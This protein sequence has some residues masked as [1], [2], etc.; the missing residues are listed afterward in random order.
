MRNARLASLA[1][2]LALPL[3]ASPRAIA[4]DKTKEA[5]VRQL[6]QMTDAEKL[7]GQVIDAMLGQVEQSGKLPPG[8]SDKF[9]EE[10]QKDK[11]VDRLVPI[12]MKRLDEKDIDGVIA[13]YKSPAGQSFLK[14]QPMIIQDE[15]AA[16]NAWGQSLYEKTM[17]DLG[18]SPAPQQ[19]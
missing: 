11:L 13:F 6:I 14:A 9:R 3:L 10:A 18:M 17:K 2:L 4:N 5:K 8:F 16:G 19:Q 7:G 12:F 15:M 1:V